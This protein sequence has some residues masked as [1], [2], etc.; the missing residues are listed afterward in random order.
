M[1]LTFL[2]REQIKQRK[3]FIL[4]EEVHILPEQ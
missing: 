4:L 1:L 2:N 3:C